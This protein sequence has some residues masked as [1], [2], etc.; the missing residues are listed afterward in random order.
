[1]IFLKYSFFGILFILIIHF[2]LKQYLTNN[3]LNNKIN[4]TFKKK[5]N[6]PKSILKQNK[7]IVN[8]NTNIKKKVCIKD[9]PPNL[10]NKDIKQKLIHYIDNYQLEN[11][12]SKELKEIN[13]YFEIQNDDIYIIPKERKSNNITPFEQDDN[14]YGSFAR[15]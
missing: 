3:T 5:T 11:N 1:M 9:P 10:E 7:L 6:F 4:N 13:K 12:N 8:N 14:F 2:I 15:Y